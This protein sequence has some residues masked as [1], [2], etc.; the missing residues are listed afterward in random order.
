MMDYTKLIYF[1]RYVN[2][3]LMWLKPLVMLVTVDG[4]DFTYQKLTKP[5]MSPTGKTE[6]YITNE[7]MYRSKFT[8]QIIIKNHIHNF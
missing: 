2:E 7:A 4:C 8:L 5:V 6:F 1:R 3:H